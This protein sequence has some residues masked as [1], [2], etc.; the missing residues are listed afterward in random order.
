MYDN[1]PSM[2]AIV[3]NT[4]S[5]EKRSTP[6]VEIFIQSVLTSDSPTKY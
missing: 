1:F 4:L 2:N 3:Q 5:L 6:Q